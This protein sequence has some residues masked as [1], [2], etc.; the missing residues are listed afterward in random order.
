MH[1]E[2][3]MELA[4]RLEAGP[5]WQSQGEHAGVMDYSELDSVGL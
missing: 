3:A 4:D 2:A 1:V 5:E